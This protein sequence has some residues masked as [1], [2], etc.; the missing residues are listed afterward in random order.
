MSRDV[1]AFA[2]QEY[3]TADRASADERASFIVKTYTHL[4]GAVLALIALDT[5]LLNLPIAQSLTQTLFGGGGYAWLLALGAFMIVSHVANRWARDATSIRTQYMGLSLYVV[6]QAIILLPLLY[7]ASNYGG[8]DVIPTAGIVTLCAFT[9]LTAIVVLTRKNFSF[10]GPFLGVAGFV[11][12]GFIV[13]SIL[14]GF[15]LGM[16]FTVLMI[17]FACGYILYDTSKVMHEYRIGQ[18]VAAS[19][20]LFASVALLFWYILQFVM[21]SRD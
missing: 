7:V 14:F 19:L 20:A 6:A 4:F 2:P 3:T 5:V 9:G 12:L 17:G 10:L 11:A 21:G 8:P 16:L 13:C 15:S 1:H 18:H